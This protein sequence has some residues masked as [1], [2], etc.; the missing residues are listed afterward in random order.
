MNWPVNRIQ[1][2]AKLYYS[3]L[4]NQKSLSLLLITFLVQYKTS[5]TIL[6]SLRVKLN[7]KWATYKTIL[8]CNYPQI[9][10]GV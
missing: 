7:L 4:R 6:L 2:N 10:F 9:H 5:N 8:F 1:K 3:F